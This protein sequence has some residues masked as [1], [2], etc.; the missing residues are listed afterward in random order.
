MHRQRSASSSHE[1]GN[2]I[3][4]PEMD[5]CKARRQLL[6]HCATLRYLDRYIHGLESIRNAAILQRPAGRRRLLRG[7]VRRHIDVSFFTGV[8]DNINI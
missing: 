8:N 3:R 2:R 7:L 4:L 6:Q 5:G 1:A